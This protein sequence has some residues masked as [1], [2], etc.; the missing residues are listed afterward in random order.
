MKA[1]HFIT[2]INRQRHSANLRRDILVRRA[3]QDIQ[4]V[5]HQIAELVHLIQDIQRDRLAEAK[6]VKPLKPEESQKRAEKDRERQQRIRD[7]QKSAS[8]RIAR[9]RAKVGI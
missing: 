9:L 2:Y 8:T 4:A 6:A 1:K 7:I 3:T 5:E